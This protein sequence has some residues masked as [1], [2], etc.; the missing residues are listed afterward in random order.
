MQG[1]KREGRDKDDIQI[2][3]LGPHV[4]RDSTYQGGEHWTKVKFKGETARSA[5]NTRSQSPWELNY[6][7]DFLVWSWKT[8]AAPNTC[9]QLGLSAVRRWPGAPAG[10][11]SSPVGHEHPHRTP[12]LDKVTQWL[13]QM[14]KKQDHFVILLGHRQQQGH[15][16]NTD[17]KQFLLPADVSDGPFLSMSVSTLPVSSFPFQIPSCRIIPLPV[18]IL[19]W[20]HVLEPSH[21]A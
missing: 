15:G 10:P 16:A 2:S 9:L 19:E 1:D 8:G 20:T 21:I 3:H 18:G 12:E 7:T 14:R 11:G 4:G 17:A 13:Q 6:G 5:L